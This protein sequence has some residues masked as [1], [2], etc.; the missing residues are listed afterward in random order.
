MDVGWN[1]AVLCRRHG[2]MQ[3]SRS[4]A[5][6]WKG[7]FLPSQRNIVARDLELSCTGKVANGAMLI[8]RLIVQASEIPY[9]GPRNS[10]AH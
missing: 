1:A 8:V 4:V 9:R 10:N 6:C 3:L 7:P 2:L 5:M